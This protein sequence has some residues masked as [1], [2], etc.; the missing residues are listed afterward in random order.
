MNIWKHVDEFRIQS[1]TTQDRVIWLV[2]YRESMIK[3]GIWHTWAAA[4]TPYKAGI[5]L[6][7]LYDKIILA[8]AKETKPF[9]TETLGVFKLEDIPNIT[10]R[11]DAIITKD[12]K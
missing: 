2:Q 1:I 3:R 5:Q 6:K 7:K 8:N 4:T 11:N 12:K 10:I 9:T